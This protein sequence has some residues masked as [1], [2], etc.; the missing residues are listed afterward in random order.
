[1]KSTSTSLNP[2]PMYKKRSQVDVYVNFPLDFKFILR[3]SAACVDLDQDNLTLDTLGQVGRD[4]RQYVVI[5]TKEARNKKYT[6]NDLAEARRKL[7][8]STH[9]PNYWLKTR[10]CAVQ[11][12]QSAKKTSEFGKPGHG[13]RLK[14]KFARSL[15][16]LRL[17]ALSVE[18]VWRSSAT[19]VRS[20]IGPW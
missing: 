6:K 3:L 11:D 18:T 5:G 12:L 4:P 15:A 9:S 10:A 14:R 8:T 20:S 16:G 1:M 7:A 19:I 13:V 17:T 2:H